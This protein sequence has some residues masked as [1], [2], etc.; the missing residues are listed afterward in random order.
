LE[1][2]PRT[3]GVDIDED[4]SELDRAGSGWRHPPFCRLSASCTS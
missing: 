2:V 3:N 1:V 4:N